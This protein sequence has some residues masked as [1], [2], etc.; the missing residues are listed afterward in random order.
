[1]GSPNTEISLI[2]SR[3]NESIRSLVVNLKDEI[4][5]GRAAG[6]PDQTIIQR[7]LERITI[8]ID[9]KVS[10]PTDATAVIRRA[11]AEKTTGRV[12]QVYSTTQGRLAASLDNPR[13]LDEILPENQGYRF[14]G[15]VNDRLDEALSRAESDLEHFER[16]FEREEIREHGQERMIWV[17]AFVNTC[18]DCLKLNGKVMTFGEWEQSGYW[19]GNGSTV[20]KEHCQCHLA[21]VR[22]MAERY[23]LLQKDASGQLVSQQKIEKQLQTMNQNG[24]KLQMK[25]IREIEKERGKRYATS[26]R[27]QM[28]GQIRTEEF[29]PNFRK[30]ESVRLRKVPKTMPKK[31]R[32]E[33]KKRTFRIP[34][35]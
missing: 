5:T 10:I 4:L 32:Q 13:A 6:V 21:P 30:R 24:I 25:K 9:G 27:Q 34:K 14:T 23:N 35:E 29:N 11:M 1:L 19:P 18:K 2:I 26:T 17:A 22:R 8:D 20:C 12:R 3:L 15:E 16:E 28:L 7:L 33:L 31:F